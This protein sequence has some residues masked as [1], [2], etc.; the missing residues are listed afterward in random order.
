MECKNYPNCDTNFSNLIAQQA[1]RI[2]DIEGDYKICK[3]SLEQLK[4][5]LIY[6]SARIKELEAELDRERIR[7]AACGSAALGYFEGCK[8]VY[9]SASLDD[10]LCLREQL[11]DLR[12]RIADAPVVVEVIHDDGSV[13]WYA[14]CDKGTKLISKEDL[15]K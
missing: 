5:D 6:K 15:Q 7:L 11:A 12:Q 10:V 4:H 3:H 2:E 8:D 13:V 14:D 9:R 1:E